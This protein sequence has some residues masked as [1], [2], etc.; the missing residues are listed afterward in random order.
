ML[1]QCAG[2]ILLVLIQHFEPRTI[3]SFCFYVS[4]IID[5][6]RGVSLLRVLQ[7]MLPS[8]RHPNGSFLACRKRRSARILAERYA[9][10]RALTRRFLAFLITVTNGA[11]NLKSQACISSPRP[12]AHIIHRRH[13]H[14]WRCTP[15]LSCSASLGEGELLFPLEIWLRHNLLMCHVLAGAV[16]VSWEIAL[17]S[18]QI[19]STQDFSPVNFS[20]LTPP[21][22]ATTTSQSR[23]VFLQAITEFGA[24]IFW[25]SKVCTPLPSFLK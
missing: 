1:C 15:P 13:V 9:M 22:P 10:P 4:A 7:Y 24:R 18:T 6:S 21:P 5:A 8:Q 12:L 2:V 23:N 3:N 17:A 11:S 25:K 14:I 20:F 16:K 19:L